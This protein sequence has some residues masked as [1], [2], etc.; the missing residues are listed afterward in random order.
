MPLSSII[1]A[2]ESIDAAPFTFREV[3]NRSELNHPRVSALEP[4]EAEP[5][6]PRIDPLQELEEMIQN[7]L[8]EAERRA[9]ELESEGYE[10]GYAQGVKDGAETG[11]KGMLITRDHLEKLLHAI[12]ALPVKIFSDYRE[13]FIASTLTVARQV[14]RKEL[15]THPRILAQ[16]IGSL[17]EEV[18][19]SQSLILYLN[20][21]DI[22][23]LE[24]H[25]SLKDILQESNRSFALKPDPG[26]QRGGCRIE[27][28]LQLLDAGIETQ[29]A[30]IEQAI[31]Q[32]EPV[33]EN[34]PS[35]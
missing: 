16:L 29:F 2:H 24:E 25:T 32:E 6:E 7:R 5:E 19:K 33:A 10:K 13:W 21:K 12:Q 35:E 18:E 8:M 27:T 34:D 20:P 15:D 30:L 1:K 28:E 22:E 14:I 4:K 17:L 9:E 31:R 23:S 11:L 26:L 3:E